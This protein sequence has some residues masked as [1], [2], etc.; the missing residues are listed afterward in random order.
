MAPTSALTLGA[1]VNYTTN[2]VTS[3]DSSLSLQG[4]G[5]YARYQ[6]T[7]AAALGVRYERLDDEGLFGGIDQVLH[8]ATVT[9]DTQAGRRLH[10]PGGVPPRRVERALLSWSS[11]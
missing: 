8:E 6:I 7:S 11:R 2:E 1:D 4:T 3:D 9:G 10:R 5:V